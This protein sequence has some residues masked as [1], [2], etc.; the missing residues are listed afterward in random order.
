MG[1]LVH[2]IMA[3]RIAGEPLWF[4][5]TENHSQVDQN[6]R[7]V[8]R[9]ISWFTQK[10]PHWLISIHVTQML[11]VDDHDPGKANRLT[12]K[13]YSWGH[14]S[15]QLSTNM[16]E[17]WPDWYHENIRSLEQ[18]GWVIPW[19]SNACSII[20]YI[21]D[22]DHSCEGFLKWGYPE[23]SSIVIGFSILNHPCY[24]S[25]MFVKPPWLG[26]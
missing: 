12:F 18:Y 14:H 24:G 19:L 2:L 20:D 4:F 8:Y 21:I 23:S 17:F 25:P 11:I 1:E 26:D 13:Q 16:C 9:N 22:H 3:T 15:H 5:S 7:D 6:T 10:K